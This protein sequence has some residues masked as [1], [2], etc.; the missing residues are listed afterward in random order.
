MNDPN[1]FD[2]NKWFIVDVG[3][4][5]A[6]DEFMVGRLTPVKDVQE[7]IE[8]YQTGEAVVTGIDELDAFKN[9]SKG[10]F[11]KKGRTK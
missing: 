9:A 6:A 1:T 11:M 2:P 10:N 4:N 8:A 5:V 3:Y 7:A